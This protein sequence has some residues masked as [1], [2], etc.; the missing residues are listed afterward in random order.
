MKV[1][2]VQYQFFTYTLYMYNDH[3][4]ILQVRVQK[5]ACT[6]SCQFYYL[7]RIVTL[8]AAT[9][10]NSDVIISPYILVKAALSKTV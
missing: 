8:S 7:P 4:N 10:E 6:L 3:I 5:S 9:C 1:Y 2:Y